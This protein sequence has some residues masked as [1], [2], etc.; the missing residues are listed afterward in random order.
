MKT[1]ENTTNLLNTIS[2]KFETGE[3]NNASMVQ[4]IELCGAYLN[5]RTISQYAKENRMSYNGAKH[6]R[7]NIT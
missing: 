3:I 2:E 5:L 7:E 6:H 1:A 4:I